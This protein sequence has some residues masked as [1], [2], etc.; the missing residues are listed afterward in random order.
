MLL[1]F[2]AWDLVFLRQCVLGSAFLRHHVVLA[3][4]VC[5]R[6]KAVNVSLLMSLS[7]SLSSSSSLLL[8]LLLL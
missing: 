8:L 5:L 3:Y 4:L 2:L 6:M 7:S 1:A